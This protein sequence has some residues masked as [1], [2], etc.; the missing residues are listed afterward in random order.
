MH[1]KELLYDI[2]KAL[3]LEKPFFK[4]VYNSNEDRYIAVIPKANIL[5]K[6]LQITIDEVIQNSVKVS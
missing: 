4:N 5:P 2:L 1:H 3:H 6:N